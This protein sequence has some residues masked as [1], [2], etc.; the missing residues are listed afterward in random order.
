MAKVPSRTSR[1]RFRKKRGDILVGQLEKE[2]GVD[3]G[4]RSDMKLE[5]YLEKEGFPSMSKVLQKLKSRQ[6]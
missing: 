3:F 2:Y 1:G 5:T 6:S 4:V